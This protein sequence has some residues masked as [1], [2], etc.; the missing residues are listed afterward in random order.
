MAM[1]LEFVSDGVAVVS[2]HFFACASIA[3]S[4]S[5]GI[6]AIELM[7]I[8]AMSLGEIESNK[9]ISTPQI[10]PIRHWF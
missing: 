3:C 10:F 2:A 7:T 6:N 4:P 5:F 8:Y 1:R 9:F